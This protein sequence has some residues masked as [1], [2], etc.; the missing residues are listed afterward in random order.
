M[1]FMADISGLQVRAAKLPEL[2]A[3][4]AVLSGGFGMGIYHS[5]EEL[6]KLP[7]DFVEYSPAMDR[8]EADHTKAGWSNAVQQI[9]HTP[10]RN[11]I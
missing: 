10:R 1:Q 11:Q 4:G 8:G 3:L 9:L 7:A 5:I 6:Q 2:S